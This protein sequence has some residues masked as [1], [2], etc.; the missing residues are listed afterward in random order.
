MPPRKGELVIYLTRQLALG[1]RRR[2]GY[3]KVGVAVKSLLV[4]ET[5]PLLIPKVSKICNRDPRHALVPRA[6]ISDQSGFTP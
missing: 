3:E 4:T 2:T 5:V 6:G 1:A